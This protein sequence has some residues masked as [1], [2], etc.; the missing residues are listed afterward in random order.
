MYEAVLLI[1]QDYMSEHLF[2]PG[3]KWPK[4]Y[5]EERS[6][7]RWVTLEIIDRVKKQKTTPPIVII[8]DFI[9][10]LDDCSSA[11]ENNR[12]LFSMA[13]DAAEDVLSLFL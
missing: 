8:E 3:P 9:R 6:Y 7:S 10:E 4:Y 12:K 2:E 5:F 11:N 1:L 13:R